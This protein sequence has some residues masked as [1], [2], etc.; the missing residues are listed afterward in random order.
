MR[1]ELEEADEKLKR[2]GESSNK[3]RRTNNLSNFKW[4][5]RKE[6]KESER[7]CTLEYLFKIRVCK[8]WAIY[9]LYPEQKCVS[10]NC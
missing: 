8:Y 10:W 4:H 1:T 6:K 7:K 2:F 9:W 5:W 3:H